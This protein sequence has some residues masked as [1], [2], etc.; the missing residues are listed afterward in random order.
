MSQLLNQRCRCHPSCERRRDGYVRSEACELH[1][2][3]IACAMAC[4]GANSARLSGMRVRDKLCTPQHMYSTCRKSDPEVHGQLPSGAP[5]S[6][7]PQ[8]M[9]QAQMNGQQAQYCV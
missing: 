1:M 4:L 2:L 7:R 5:M 8:A 6:N 9:Y 3:Y